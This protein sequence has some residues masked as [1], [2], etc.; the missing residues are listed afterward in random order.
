MY[1]LR[2]V[3]TLLDGREWRLHRYIT[4]IHLHS[5]L[6]LILK[7]LLYLQALPCNHRSLS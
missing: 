5:V 3:K 2:F 6:V 1:R 7:H 4:L